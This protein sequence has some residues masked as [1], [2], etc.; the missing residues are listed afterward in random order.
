M[1][2]IVAGDWHSDIHEEAIFRAFEF[3]GH[4]VFRFSWC[5]YFN[6]GSNDQN[7][8]FKRIQRKF[9]IGPVVNQINLDLL[10][11][12]EATRPDLIFLYR[13][14]HIFSE[15]LRKIKTI[16]KSI[17]ICSY[18]NDDP[19][20]PKY[21]KWLWRHYIDSIKY[22]DKVFVYRK[23][24]ILDAQKAGAKNVDLLRSWYLPWKDIPVN[25]D[26]KDRGVFG[27][28]V[29]FVGHYEND[30]RLEACEALL[31]RNVD[32]K[33]FGPYK[34]LG[35]SG[36]Y[37]RIDSQSL[38]ANQTPLR[39]LAGNDY[40]KAISGTRIGLCFL[41]KLNRDTYTRRCFEIPACGAALFSEYSEDLATLYPEG[42]EA[43]FFRSQDELVEKVQSYLL[44]EKLLSSLTVAGTERLKADGHDV[45]SRVRS[46]ICN[47]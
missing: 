6:S 43:E 27:S 18:N 42:S 5:Q 36:W 29:T 37:G 24:N 41:S 31:R 32:L 1:R 35:K 16:D 20:S 33:L 9:M 15:T 40:V 34:G 4:E 7:S 46:L 2:V 30:G 47:L 21:P 3:L 25:L 44:Y 26:E 17:L 22:C 28:D 39:W 19:F 45:V 12:T 11:L 23:S 14:S 8:T 10:K 13:G 38:L